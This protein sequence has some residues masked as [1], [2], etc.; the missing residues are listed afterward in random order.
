MQ[1]GASQTGQGGA[2]S[3]VGEDCSHKKIAKKIEPRAGQ[4]N[5]GIALDDAYRHLFCKDIVIPV[6]RFVAP[7]ADSFAKKSHLV[8]R[9]ADRESAVKNRRGGTVSPAAWSIARN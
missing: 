9:R 7:R 4:K 3:R 5:V 8:A 6:D 2:G 1:Q